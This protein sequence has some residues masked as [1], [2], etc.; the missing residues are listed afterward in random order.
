MLQIS[1][2]SL[3][4][5]LQAAACTAL[6]PHAG[7]ALQQFCV[8]A[9]RRGAA[10]VAEAAADYAL[11]QPTVTVQINNKTIDVPEGTSILKAATQL[12]IHVSPAGGCPTLPG[13]ARHLP[14]Y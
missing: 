10:T 8:Q 2:I 1:S 5:A 7:R 14:R 9:Q 13:G 4:C 11:Q 6:L 12:G 3:P